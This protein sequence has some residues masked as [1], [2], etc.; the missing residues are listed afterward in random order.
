[1][2]EKVEL[3]GYHSAWLA[4]DNPASRAEVEVD[5]ITCE[6]GLGATIEELEKPVFVEVDR[7]HP[8]TDAA[9]AGA[10]RLPLFTHPQVRG[11]VLSARCMSTVTTRITPIQVERRFP[12]DLTP[13]TTAIRQLYE[14]AKDR[15]LEPDTRPALGRRSTLAGSRARRARR[16]AAGLEPPRMGRVHRPDARRRRC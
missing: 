16:S 15:A 10:S 5:R 2:I 14:A 7:A 12:L 1:M 11:A 4:P 8:P 6:A 13:P 3:N 9:R